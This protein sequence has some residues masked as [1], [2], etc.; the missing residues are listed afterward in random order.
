M[1]VIVPSSLLG[2]TPS[3]ILHT[4]GGVWV[5]GYEAQD[6]AAIFAGDTLETKPE[7]SATLNLEGSN[8]LIQPQSVTKFQGDFLELDHGGVAVGSAT[9]FKVR[10]HCITVT[11]VVSDWTQYEVTDV[12]GTV[13]VAAR[14][15]D[16]NVEIVE[17]R[18]PGA[19]SAGSNSGTVHE[20]EEHNYDESKVCGAPAKLPG[21]AMNPKYFEI[22][23][24][25][26]GGVL[27][28]AVVLCKGKGGGTKP[29][30]SSSP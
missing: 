10:V 3:A 28:C 19:E 29:M 16:V 6:S 22:G 24:A 30:S 7:F 21:A 4:Q 13:H 26:L 27:I 1:L 11:P 25:A 8:V 2:Q 9:R 18:K 5:N 14:K 20:G 23:G 17:H 15:N 12:N